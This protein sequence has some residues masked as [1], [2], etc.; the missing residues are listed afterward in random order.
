[1][2]RRTIIPAALV[3]V[4]AFGSLAPAMAKPKRKPLSKSYTVTAPVPHPLPATGPSCGDDSGAQ[5][6]HRETLKIPAAGKL[7]VTV[8][9]FYG[10]W[11]IGLY[12]KAGN[13]AEGD[14]TDTGPGFSKGDGQEV[15]VAKIKKPGTYFIDVCNFMGSSSAKAKYTFVFA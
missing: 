6:E 15:L 10:D 9:G 7:T 11:D 14:G 2:N 13:L 1:M 3:A 12:S 5:S 8:S 4:V